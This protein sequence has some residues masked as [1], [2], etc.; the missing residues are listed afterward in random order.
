MHE[1]DG[2]SLD[3]RAAGKTAKTKLSLKL[4]GTGAVFT[5]G[6]RKGSFKGMS[7]TRNFEVEFHLD[8][9]PVS[10]TV[11]GKSAEGVWNGSDKT[12]TVSAGEV[13]DRDVAVR[14]K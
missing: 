8:K 5:V 3:Y 1:D 14:I 7:P 11:D 12:F 9:A 6:A 4:D 2:I 10:V 13:G